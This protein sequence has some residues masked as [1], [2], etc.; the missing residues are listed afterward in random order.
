VS[1]TGAALENTENQGVSARPSGRCTTRCTNSPNPLP[2]ADLDA[3]AVALL[4]LSPEECDR[5]AALLWQATAKQSEGK[6]G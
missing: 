1:N 6:G 4:A 5:L 2:A 3:L